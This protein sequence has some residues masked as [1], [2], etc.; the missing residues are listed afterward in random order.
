MFNKFKIQLATFLHNK[1]QNHI[2]NR[3]PDFIVGQ[4]YLRRWWIIPRNPIFNIYYHNFRVSDDDRAKHDHMYYNFSFL[5][6]GEYL[7]HT[8]NKI[9]HRK[10]GDITG[11][12][13]PWQLHRIEL[14]TEI[15]HFTNKFSRGRS[16]ENVE[17]WTLFITGPRIRNWGFQV[18]P[19]VRNWLG[20]KTKS[21][22]MDHETYIETYGEQLN[23]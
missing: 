8:E 9:F 7:E 15:K 16:V 2:A 14:L 19:V 17:C 20:F 11:I 5:L 12:R 4:M 1:L 23:N 21:G 6:S 3:P 18:G 22:W 13:S 10:T